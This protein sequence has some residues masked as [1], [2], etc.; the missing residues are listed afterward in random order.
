MDFSVHKVYSQ[1]IYLCLK[2]FIKAC[3][4]KVHF[5]HSLQKVL[6]NREKAMPFC[7]CFKDGFC[8][9]LFI[10]QLL[11]NAFCYSFLDGFSFRFVKLGTIFIGNNDKVPMIAK[12]STLQVCRLDHIVYAQHYRDIPTLIHMQTLFVILKGHLFQMQIVQYLSGI[13]ANYQ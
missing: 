8:L 7:W 4:L 13:A 9:S 5:W 10:K 6:Q 1:Y 12:T 11:I 2:G 3:I